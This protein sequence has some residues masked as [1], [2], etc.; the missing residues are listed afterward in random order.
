MFCFSLLHLYFKRGDGLALKK[1]KFFRKHYWQKEYSD[2]GYSLMKGRWI[3]LTVFTVLCT[4]W[5]FAQEAALVPDLAAE[6]AAKALK[7]DPTVIQPI[8]QRDTTPDE[9][10]SGLAEFKKRKRSAEDASIY[11][12]PDARTMT[13]SIPGPRGQITDRNGKPFAQNK[14]VWYP[15]LQFGQLENADREFVV[16]WAK[17]RIAIAN[18]IFGINWEV[19]EDRLWEHYRHRRWLPMPYTHVVEAERRE[20]LAPKLIDGLI[21]HPRYM[22]VYPQGA[23]AAH[24]VGYVGNAGKLE[25]GPINY[26]DPL[27]EYTEGRAG[28]EKFFNQQLKGLEGLR[29]MQYDS[30]GALLERKESRRPKAGGT[31]VTTIDLEWQQRAEELLAEKTTRGAMAVVDVQTGEVLVLASNPSYDLNDWVPFISSKKYNALKDDPAKPLYARAF[32]GVYPPASTFKPIVALASLKAN[33]LDRLRKIDCPAYIKLGKHKFNDWSKRSRGLLNLNSAM[34]LSNNPFFIKIALEIGSTKVLD[35]ARQVGF[36]SRTGLPLDD[37]AGLVP[38]NDWMIRNEK[39]SFKDGDTANMAIGQGVILATPLQ[40]AQAMSAIA[41]GG[42]LPRLQLIRQ[43]Q[44]AEGRVLLANQLEER[45]KIGVNPMD[46]GL[47]Q[48]G[49][50]NVVNS[51]YGT[52]K[53]GSLSYSIVCGKTGTGQWGPASKKKYVGWFSG[54]FPL[55]NPK[56]AFAIVYE[57]AE[58]EEISGGRVAGPLVPAFF[59]PIREQVERLINPPARAMVIEDESE[60]EG[61]SPVGGF[62]RAVLVEKDPAPEELPEPTV[63]PRAAIVIEEEGVFD[64]D[65]IDPVLPPPSQ[66]PETDDS[67]ADGE[68][69]ETGVPQSEEPVGLIETP[70]E[71]STEEPVPA[72]ALIIE[73]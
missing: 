56:F 62:S 60:D 54:F 32:Q 38:T 18:S 8:K 4:N 73:E 36:G 51:S 58:N 12:R 21:L 37:A 22:R 42:S 45:N 70:A 55:D 66:N 46:T 72:R 61:L 40:V 47:V 48:E 11:T 6:A 2:L 69:L 13:L 26:G 64:P 30:N 20:L 29:K 14:V 53:S 9:E 15:A 28:L 50:M 49:M 3:T 24:I 44:D 43:I 68:H 31:L 33:R 7:N 1:V 67:E 23:T 57:G 39:R 41:N 10:G 34:A 17:E 65:S 5:I 16:N 63:A 25:K 19:R 27:F 35:M 59:E 71:E 52:G